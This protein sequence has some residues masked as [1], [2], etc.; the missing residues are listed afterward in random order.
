MAGRGT[1]RQRLPV[2]LTDAEVGRLMAGLHTQSATGL[3]NRALLQVMVG[4][5]L[6]LAEAL[7]LRVGDVDL[8]RGM[9]RINLGKGGKDRVVPVGNETVRWLTD[10]VERREALG[11]DGRATLFCGIRTHGAQ[12]KSRAVQRLVERLARE[13]GIEKRVTPHTL[14]H[15]FATRLLRSGF[16]LREVQQMLGHAGVATTQIYTHVDPVDLAAKV[17]A[18]DAK[19]DRL[20]AALADLTAA[21]RERI[22]EAVRPEV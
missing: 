6:R 3:R 19:A 10:W 11:Y 9:L 2:A 8:E 12:L 20:Q 13:A 16:N 22:L 5:G 1:R 17:K 14:R 18:N 15:T 7:A 4:G 21:E